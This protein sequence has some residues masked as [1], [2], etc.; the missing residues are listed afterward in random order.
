MALADSAVHMIGADYLI[1]HGQDYAHL[2][3]RNSYGQFIHDYYSYQ[4]PVGCRHAVRRQRV[5]AGAAADLG[6]PAVQRVH[7]R[8]RGR[9]RLAARAAAAG[10]TALAA[11]AALTAVLPALVYAY[12][13]FGSIKEMTALSMI[14]T[15]GCLVGRCTAAGCPRRPRARS[16][17]RS[18]SPPACPRSG[19]AFGAWALAAVRRA[20]GRA[21]RRAARAGARCRL[22]AGARDG[23]ARRAR[24]ADRGVA[25][26]DATVGV[27]AGRPEHRH[28]GQ[29]RQPARAA[30]R[31][32]GASACGCAAATSSR[33]PAPRSRHR[34]ADRAHVRSRRCSARVHLLRGT[35]V[36]AA[37]AGSRDAAGVAGGEPLGDH[38]G[39]RQDADAH[40]ARGR[41]ARVGRGRCAALALARRARHGS[42]RRCSRSRSPAACSSPTRCSTTA[43]TSRRPPAT[44]SSPRSTPASPGRGPTLF[45]D[46]DEYAMYEL[47]DLD[48]GGPDFVYPPPAL[49]AAAGGYGEPVELDRVAP[50]ALRAYP[51]IVTRRDPAASRPPA[52]YALLW[53]GSYYQVWGGARARRAASRARRAVGLARAAV[54]AHRA[55]AARG[56]GRRGRAAD[57]RARAAADLAARS[58]APAHPARWGIPAGHRR[59]RGPRDERVGNACLRASRC[60]LAGA[61]TCGSRARSCPAVKLGVDGRPDRLDRRTA[62]RQLARARHRAAGSRAASAGAHRVSVTRAAAS[63]SRRATAARPCSTRSSLRPPAPTRGDRCAQWRPPTGAALCGRRYQWIE[64]TRE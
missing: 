32:P 18:C 22:G 47:R 7:A 41:A 46:F 3:L 49:A 60:P 29:R 62:R 11:L 5:P 43:P 50:S 23:R 36:R 35:R 64:I 10:W 33:P 38:V 39:G 2:D 58:P 42:P 1:R 16:R 52:A 27:S 56:A 31:H 59:A 37:R 63:A 30:A 40:L 17:S 21:R 53:Q 26:L 54:R 12:E 9:A 28:H 57:R 48:V 45:T 6:V 51:L 20:R 4:L 8:H 55:L 13:L 34:R 15:L 61:G 44:R 25:D 24:A 14:L 19:I